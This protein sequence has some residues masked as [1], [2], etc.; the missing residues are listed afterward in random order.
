MKIRTRMAGA[1]AGTAFAG[2]TAL[3][4]GTAAPAGAQQLQPSTQ[5]VSAA[6]QQATVAQHCWDGD[7]GG[8]WDDDGWDSWGGGWDSWYGGW[9]GW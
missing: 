4:V 6:P 1:V 5:T 9:G 8:G 3:A 2:L 7:C